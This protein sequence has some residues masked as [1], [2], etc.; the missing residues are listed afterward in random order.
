M[1][2]G[3]RFDGVTSMMYTHHGI[4]TG[5][6]GASSALAR[7]SP[8]SVWGLEADAR[9]DTLS[10]SSGAGGYHEYFGDNVDDEAVVYLMLVRAASPLPPP[11]PPAIPLRD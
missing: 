5:F 11:S 4:G 3:F 6:S 7:P 2:D 10:V 9:C 1:F 8:P